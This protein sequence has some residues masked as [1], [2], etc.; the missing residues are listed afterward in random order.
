ML[1]IHATLIACQK[2]AGMKNKALSL[3]NGSKLIGGA[4]SN[5]SF[6]FLAIRIM[7]RQGSRN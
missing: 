5:E 3:N 1:E 7:F 4:V 2:V 6:S